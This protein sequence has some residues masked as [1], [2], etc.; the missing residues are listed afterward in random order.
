VY[1]LQQA[2][3]SSPGPLFEGSPGVFYSDADSVVI[4]SVTSQGTATALATFQD[5]PSLIASNPIAG[6]NGLLY[7]SFQTKEGGPT[8]WTPIVFSVSSAAGSQQNYPASDYMPSFTQNLPGGT[9]LAPAISVSTGLYYLV[10]SDL[11]AC[12]KSRL[13]LPYRDGD[14][15]ALL[16]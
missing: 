10:T 15:T 8:E 1:V 13:R 2:L 11:R 14:A 4:F 9:L 12:L 16:Y 3:G 5:P 6:A 7:S